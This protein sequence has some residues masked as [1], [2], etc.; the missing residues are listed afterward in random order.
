MLGQKDCNKN[1][2][3][4]LKEKAYFIASC[5]SKKTF[6]L[7]S[8]IVLGFICIYLENNL[9]ENQYFVDSVVEYFFG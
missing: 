2:P 6:F 8:F 5:K 4:R 9:Q 7:N 3:V 1:L